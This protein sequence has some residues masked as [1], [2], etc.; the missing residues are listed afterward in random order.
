M[1]NMKDGVALGTPCTNTTRF[2][3]GWDANGN[4]LACRSPLPGEQSQWVPGGKL[5]GVRAIRSEC[6]LDV[7]GQSPDFR[8]HVAA[9]SPDGLPLF[10]EYPWN[11]WAVHPAA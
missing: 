7:Y 2:V 9:Q 6:I 8:Q 1:P 11:F 3:F 4:V 10:C 5:V